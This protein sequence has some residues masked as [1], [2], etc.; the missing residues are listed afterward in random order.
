VSSYKDVAN[1]RF[2]IVAINTNQ[3]DV[4]QPFTIRNQLITQFTPYRTSAAEN[5]SQLGAVAVAGGSF[6]YPLP[7][8][9]V[10]TFVH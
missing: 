9:S 1:S 7:G 10:T 5:I 8:L 6:N 2:V 3:S 4:V